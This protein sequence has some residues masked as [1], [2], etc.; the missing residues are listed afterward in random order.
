MWPNG[1]GE[2]V[3]VAIRASLGHL[4]TERA[5]TGA[6]RRIGGNRE[7]YVESLSCGVFLQR[8]SS[9][10]HTKLSVTVD[11]AAGWSPTRPADFL[12][13]TALNG[14]KWR[15]LEIW[16]ISKWGLDVGRCGLSIGCG[17]L[18]RISLSRDVPNCKTQLF[19]HFLVHERRPFS[20]DQM[21][22]V[23]DDRNQY[24]HENR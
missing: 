14:R 24:N 3:S 22:D 4:K 19:P 13:Q 23:G 15:G 6:G 8:N 17:C 5:D 10:A 11:L 1:F 12:F 18:V 2:P 20:A 7:L 9:R 16:T 21:A